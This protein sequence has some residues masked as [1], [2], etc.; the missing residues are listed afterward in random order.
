MEEMIPFL[1][2]FEACFCKILEML[3]NPANIYLFKFNNKNSKNRCEICSKLT[4]E[5]PERRL[6]YFTPFDVLMYFWTYFTPFSAVSV[7]DFE[8]VN[9]SWDA[10]NAFPVSCTVTTQPG[11][12]FFKPTM[13]TPEQRLKICFRLNWDVQCS[14][15]H[16]FL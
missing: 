7:V 8:Q 10:N 9:I 13:E 14:Q 4:I 11:F 15:N 5:T 6:M 12:T 1:V 3:V 2:C 16:T